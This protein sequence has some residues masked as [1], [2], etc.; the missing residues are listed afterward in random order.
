M[1]LKLNSALGILCAFLLNSCTTTG[2]GGLFGKKSPHE[3]YG[4]S[5]IN[6]GL[7]ES[8]LGRGWFTAAE[9]SL[10]SPL[11]ITIPYKETGY[12]PVEKTRATALRF[13]AKRGEKISISLQKRPTQN[14]T[15]YVDLWEERQNNNKKLLAF[16]DTGGKSFSHDIDDSGF[17]IIRLQPELL[18]AGEYTLTITNGPS[19]A[20]PVQKG[21]IG[22]FWGAARDAGARSH[23]GI[24]IFAKKGTPAIAA[25]DGN[26]SRVT[27]NKLGGKVVFMRPENK[28]YSLYYAHLDEQLVSDGQKVKTGDKIGLVGNTGNAISTAPHLHF[29][30]YTAGGAIDPLAFVNPDVKPVPAIKSSLANLGGSMRTTNRT[31]SLRKGMATN[32]EIITSMDANTLVEIQ[33]ATDNLYKVILP[34]GKFGFL[35]GSAA[36]PAS[37][38]VQKLKLRTAKELFDNPNTAAARKSQLAAGSTVSILGDFETYHF[39]KAEENSGWISKD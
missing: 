16:A 6:A 9:Q 10:A 19:L 33:A 34:D 28:N 36:I 20:F 22:S 3:Q 12:F 25:A 2:P 13:E 38:P 29:G 15:I 21:K 1:K 26:V 30:I 37:T 31:I 23:E 24:D 35:T 39:V 7:K 8:A 17:Y 32:S 27:T 5:L 14:F 4:Q 11:G 18:S